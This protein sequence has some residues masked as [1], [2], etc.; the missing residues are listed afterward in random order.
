MFNLNFVIK[1]PSENLLIIR[2]KHFFRFFFYGLGLFIMIFVFR[3]FD[4][5]VSNIGP[6]IF[7]GI[8][9]LLGSYYESWIFDKS[10]NVVEQRQGLLFFFIK[11]KI[12]LSDVK[13]VSLNRFIKGSHL[14]STPAVENQ[15]RYKLPPKEY[16]KLS[17]MLK[18]DEYQV[19]EIAQGRE[20]EKFNKKAR[21]LAQFCNCPLVMEK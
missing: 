4:Q 12:P 8:C 17:L 2:F 5:N 9:A 16:Y 15:K 11:K 1:K 20:I 10:R 18:D 3:E 6:Y 13:G 21:S 14:K 7:I 19:V